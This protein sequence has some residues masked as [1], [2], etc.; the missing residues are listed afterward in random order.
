MKTVNKILGEA[1][2]AMNQQKWQTA[3]ELYEKALTKYPDNS[4]A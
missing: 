3:V 4:L 2:Q 1:D